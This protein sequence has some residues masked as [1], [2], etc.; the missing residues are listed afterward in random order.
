MATI[1]INTMA[2]GALLIYT[3]SIDCQLIFLID[4]LPINTLPIDALPE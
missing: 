4:N 2:L 1:D 3:L